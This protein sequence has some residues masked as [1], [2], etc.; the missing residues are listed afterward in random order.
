MAQRNLDSTNLR[1]FICHVPETLLKISAGKCYSPG[2]TGLFLIY[3]AN[4]YA[5]AD[6]AW[7]SCRPTIKFVFAIWRNFTGN[8]AA[9]QQ[10]SG[11]ATSSETSSRG[12]KMSNHL[13]LKPS[14]SSSL[15]RETDFRITGPNVELDQVRK[16]RS[17]NECLVPS[18][19]PPNIFTA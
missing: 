16:S 6:T 3:T 15:Y 7:R 8:N 9:S 11:D 17:L 14:S 1:Y 2:C 12:N 19:A 4:F 18:P 5:V 13:L 10:R